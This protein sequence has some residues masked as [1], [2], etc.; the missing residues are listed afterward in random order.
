MLVNSTGNP[1][2]AKGGSG[3]V[4]TGLIGGLIARGYPSRD[5]AALGVWLHG[6]AGDRLTEEFT[7][8]CYSSQDLIDALWKGFQDLYTF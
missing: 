1:G 2:L 5:A 8:E 6:Y 3:D 7:P 4:L